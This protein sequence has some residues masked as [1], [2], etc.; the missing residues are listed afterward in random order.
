MLFSRDT[1]LITVAWSTWT[2]L[3]ADPGAPVSRT[4][5][6]GLAALAGLAAL[7]LLRLTVLMW[8]P[9][10]RGLTVLAV[11]VAIA[12]DA[13]ALIALVGTVLPALQ[14]ATALIASS[15]VGSLLARRRQA[16]TEAAADNSRLRALATSRIDGHHVAARGVLTDIEH[17]IAASVAEYEGQS[18]RTT[19]S[20]LRRIPADVMR[21][22]SHEIG[23]ELLR[24]IP[25]VPAAPT[26]SHP[27]RID[28][29]S[30][31]RPL[32]LATALTAVTITIEPIAAPL[33]FVLTLASTALVRRI[34]RMLPQQSSSADATSTALGLMLTAVPA[35]LAYQSILA[36]AVG[37]A[38]LIGIAA[39]YVAAVVRETADEEGSLIRNNAQLRWVAARV[40]L[41][42]W[43]QRGEATR[44]LHGPIQTIAATAVPRIEQ[45]IASGETTFGPVGELQRR[46]VHALGPLV[47]PRAEALDLERELR[48]VVDTWAGIADV[49][50]LMDPDILPPLSTDP[51]CA[52]AVVD[53]VTEACAEAVR[54]NGATRIVVTLGHTPG[55]TF[56]S[57]SENGSVLNPLDQSIGV[58]ILDTCSLAWFRKHTF[59]RNLMN[60]SLPYLPDADAAWAMTSA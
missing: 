56:V 46:I 6:V 51:A 29:V 15:A 57:V 20:Q 58:R 33:T 44:A 38:P 16:V 19:I 8:L 55:T 52:M 47:N 39:S 13:A 45:A 34:M 31:Q 18:A 22:I 11:V 36:L 5:L 53:V 7:H 49:E 37:T 1:L 4:A 10:H 35:G 25:D 59:G 43:Y 26:H 23:A 40:N 32:L 50:F 28:P 27:R 9:A 21:P 24:W 48:D 42:D 17:V 12:A 60:A 41:V 54:E 14:F 30:V 3:L 2:S